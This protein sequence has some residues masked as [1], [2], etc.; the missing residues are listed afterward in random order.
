MK[1]TQSVFDMATRE[2]HSHANC[3]IIMTF[4]KPERF[5]RNFDKNVTPSGRCYTEDSRS[6]TSK[7]PLLYPNNPHLIEILHQKTYMN[8]PVEREKDGVKLNYV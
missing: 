2:E 6:E 1:R 5:L 7:H 4:D 3:E 8:T